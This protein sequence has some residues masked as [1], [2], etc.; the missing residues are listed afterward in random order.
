MESDNQS[1]YRLY[2]SEIGQDNTTKTTILNTNLTGNS[3]FINLKQLKPSKTLNKLSY[4]GHLYISKS[5]NSLI[6]YVKSV[7][8]LIKSL[9]SLAC[10]TWSYFQPD[11][12]PYLKNLPP[13]WR[14]IR[15]NN[16]KF[17]PSIANYTIDPTC[18]P[19]TSYGS[20]SCGFYYPGS[21]ACYRSTASFTLNGHTAGQQCCYDSTG[22]LK[23]G[24]PGGGTLD[25]G[26]WRNAW[27]HL[28]KDV[29]P[30][31]QCCKLSNNCDIY[32][33]W[34]PSQDGTG[35][36]APGSGAGSGDPHFITLDGL[37]F[38][39]N[40]YGEFVFL[41]V[42]ETGFQIQVR[43][44]PIVEKGVVSE[45]TV[46]KAV[47]AKGLAMDSIQIDLNVLNRVE[48]FV[49]GFLLDMNE[50]ADLNV[51][52]FNGVDLIFDLVELSYAMQFSNGIRIEVKLSERK[53]A[54]FL[55]TSVPSSLQNKTSG[56][57]GN[58]I[59]K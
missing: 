59:F 4:I 46:F 19:N 21:K 32:Y 22:L 12:L 20:L 34:R 52:N 45:G 6:S 7:K 14:F 40:G 2:Y 13:C 16:G 31:F 10:E 47:A 35:W 17:P 49:D 38:T 50:F 57:M 23:V 39:F 5:D 29:V 48:V 51:I 27:D 37:E 24:P 36:V 9:A 41:N 54:L 55:F 30:F 28:N 18:D 1:S 43:I 3:T 53:D 11:P 26:H 15:L 42:A 8:F 33:K 58:E 56:L 25:L 44:G